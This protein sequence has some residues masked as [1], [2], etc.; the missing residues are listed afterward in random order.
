VLE[1][2]RRHDLKISYQELRQQL[3]G[4]EDSDRTPTGVILVRAH[5]IIMELEEEEHKLHSMLRAAH[6]R[7]LKMQHLR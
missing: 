4:I 3:P 2:K 6:A 1:R 7:K 5:E